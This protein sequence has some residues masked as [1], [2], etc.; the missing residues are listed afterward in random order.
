MFLA[1]FKYEGKGWE[2]KGWDG[3]AEGTRPK[4]ITIQ[5]IVRKNQRQ[6]NTAFVS[7]C[8]RHAN[9]GDGVAG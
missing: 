9:Q 3:K 7:M 8:F 6:H 2:G 5:Q 4:T 1:T